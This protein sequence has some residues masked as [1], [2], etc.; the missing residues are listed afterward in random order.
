MGKFLSSRIRTRDLRRMDLAV[1]PLVLAL[2][3]LPLLWF[4][5]NWTVTGD[6][7]RYLLLGWNLI[8]GGGYTTFGDFYAARGP[9]FPGLLGGLM[10]LFGRDVESLAWTVRLLALANPV[11]MYFLIKRIAGPKAGLLAA[12]IVASFSWTAT[13][14]GA[15]NIDAVQLTVYL[16]AVLVLLVGARKDSAGLSLLSGLL[17]GAAILTKETSLVT[18]PLALFAALLL[19]W[20][21]RGV[22]LHYTGVA[23]V[24]L[25]WLIWVWAVGGEVYP[26]DRLPSGTVILVAAALALVVLFV[27]GWYGR[28]GIVVRLL[29]NERWR[30]RISWFVVLAPTAVLSVLILSMS[31]GL[32]SQGEDETTLWYI[33][34]KLSP[35]IRLWYLL[36]F[37]GV[38]VLWETVRGNRLWEFY[39]ALLVLQTPV[40]L[41]VAQEQWG[42]RQWLIPQTLLYGALAGL[43]VKVLGASIR[44]ERHSLHQ[45]LAFGAATVLVIVLAQAAVSQIRYLLFEDV[46]VRYPDDIVFHKANSDKNEINPAVRDMHNWIAVNIPEGEKIITT[47]NYAFQLAFLDGMQHGWTALQMDY[48]AGLSEGTCQP[49]KIVAFEMDENC[50]GFA[51]PFTSLIGQMERSGAKYLLTT[52]EKQIRYP[53]NL[54]WAPYLESSGAFETVYSSYLP[55]APTTERSYGLVLLKRTGRD[56]TPAPTLMKSRTVKNLIRCERE[57]WGEQHAERIRKAFPDGIE[58]I[59]SQSEA[60]A[61]RRAIE[62]IYGT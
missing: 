45:L 53:A 7:P 56:P 41:I 25:P 50:R 10:Y 46:Y 23:A 17:L 35:E 29:A 18:L 32:F 55:G 27:V 34:E 57:A 9:A 44:K 59:G 22:L 54:A 51:L 49:D 28:S 26:L 61:A 37:A 16:L 38:Y 11:L 3:I 14:E 48:C 2:S 24:C 20:S 1:F 52:Q 19:G 4:G 6:A 5:R 31:S 15:F 36:P 58:V 33:M 12:A 8:S 30:R 62:E 47:E 39:L 60:E 43:I 13:F 42:T 21:F 40:F